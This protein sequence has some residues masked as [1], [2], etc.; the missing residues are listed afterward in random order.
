MALVYI[1]HRPDGAVLAVTYGRAEDY[2]EYLRA[3]RIPFKV[4]KA[5]DDALPK[6]GD[7]FALERIFVRGGKVEVV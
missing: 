6:R 2:E 3:E 4:H 5:Q 1:Y 7:A